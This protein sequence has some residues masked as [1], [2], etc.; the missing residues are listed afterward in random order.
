MKVNKVVI[1]I[2]V[3]TTKANIKVIIILVE[4]VIEEEKED[5]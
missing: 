1:A 2:T 5:L 4:L 3:V